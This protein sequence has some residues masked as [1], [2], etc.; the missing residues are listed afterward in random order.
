MARFLQNVEQGNGETIKEYIAISMLGREPV[1]S[2]NNCEYPPL[3]AP[4]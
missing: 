4:W 3:G 1:A 2:F